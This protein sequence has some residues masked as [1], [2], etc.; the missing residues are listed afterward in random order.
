[1]KIIG[2]LCDSLF[3]EFRKNQ[4]CFVT[5]KCGNKHQAIM[6]LDV[7]ISRYLGTLP[8]KGLLWICLLTWT[9]SRGHAIEVDCCPHGSLLMPSM[10]CSDGTRIHLMCPHG[11][12]LIDPDESANDN[13]T[14][15][16]EYGKPWLQFTETEYEKI[17]AN[18]FCVANRKNASSKIA[19]VCFEGEHYSSST[20]WKDTLFCILS[21][22]SAIFLIATIAV[23]VLLPELREVQ[24]KAM[25]AAV[26]S[27][28]VSYIVLSIQN[29]RPQEEGD[30]TICISLGFI[31]YFGFISVFFWLNIVSFNIWRTVWFKH[32]M[33]KDKLLFTI[34]CLCGFGGPTCFL[35]AALIMHHIDGRHLK[36]GFGEETCWFSG[37]KQMWAY[38]YGPIAIL[39]TLNI[40]YLGLTSWK[41]WHQCRDCHGGKLK[42]L[43]FKFLLYVKLIFVMGVTWIFEVLSYADGSRN[44]FWIPT[45]ILNALQGFI[46]FLLLVATRKR[47]RKLLA[48]KRPCGIGFPKSWTAYKDEECEDVVLAEEVELSQH[49]C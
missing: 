15:I 7:I 40:I 41:L 27:L 42:A 26:T 17:A 4:T 23:Y 48:K 24:D 9:I 33:I 37:P 34:Y 46:I 36:P 38:F 32:F 45:D 16:Y 31:L 43:R 25:M 20:I 28:A 39:L 14:V 5:K 6:S 3:V 30:Y 11:S 8:I 22:I 29:L 18:R 21:I 44:N 2:D 19:F 13:F 35:I 47:V 49:D 1:M 10:N 12:Y